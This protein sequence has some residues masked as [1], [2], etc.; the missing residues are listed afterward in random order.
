[1]PESEQFQRNLIFWED[2]EIVLPNIDILKKIPII[3]LETA[4]NCLDKDLIKKSFSVIL[5][6]KIIERIFAISCILW[7]PS[8]LLIIH[9]QKQ[10]QGE[11]PDWILIW[12]V[13]FITMI[14]FLL[15]ILKIVFKDTKLTYYKLSE[16][17]KETLA[18]I[19]WYKYF[20]EA[21]DEK[22]IKTF[23]EQDSEYLEKNM[24]YAISLWVETEIIESIAP[25]LLDWIN[26][27]RY[28]WDIYS[29]A[30]TMITSS[31]CTMLFP[32][33]KEW[34]Q[35]EDKS[36]KNKKINKIKKEDDLYQKKAEVKF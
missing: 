32:A 4:K 22:K 17:W 34:M 36:I 18:K 5:K 25:N 29:T 7:F 19:Y 35:K 11:L 23:L 9:I 3:N 33:E 14:L 2:K 28:I 13:G 20:L 1:M 8:I 27:N 10:M 16:K 26:N 31:E 21:C 15:V 30:K 24:P 12:W 6:S